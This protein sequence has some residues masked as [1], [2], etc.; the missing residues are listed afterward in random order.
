MVDS[1]PN[2]FT[3]LWTRLI[4]IIART[5]LSFSSRELFAD[6]FA[7]GTTPLFLPS[8]SPSLPSRAA[9]ATSPP[10]RYTSRSSAFAPLT[11]FAGPIA[12]ALLA[13]NQLSGSK[14]GYGVKNY[15]G[16]L[17][18]LRCKAADDVCRDRCSLTLG[19]RWFLVVLLGCCIGKDRGRTRCCK[20][21]FARSAKLHFSTTGSPAP[22]A[23]IVPLPPHAS[24]ILLLCLLA[25]LLLLF[26]QSRL[27]EDPLLGQSFP[28]EV[29]LHALESKPIVLLLR[30]NR[31]LG[32]TH[33]GQHFQSAGVMYLDKRA[34]EHRVAALRRTRDT[35]IHDD[36][37]SISSIYHLVRQPLLIFLLTPGS[38]QAALQ[39]EPAC[40]GQS[41][42]PDARASTSS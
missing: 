42:T 18:W 20:G 30:R 16:R 14:G 3:A 22:A 8:S 40:A 23:S 39:R 35:A 36:S 19:S 2:S 12:S 24:P 38:P 26:L 31:A 6:H 15:V 11:T 28:R 32:S 1:V 7:Q 5:S 27:D 37:F 9:S 33:S 13:G 29:L 21:G 4:T 34:L 25:L 17:E 10:V 41:R